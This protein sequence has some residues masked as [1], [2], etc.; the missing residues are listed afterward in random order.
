M[1]S[2]PKSFYNSA[3]WLAVRD[4]YLRQHPLC[5]DCLARGQYEIAAHVHHIIWLTPENYLNP[6]I[7]LNP[8]N[9]RAVCQPCHNM[10]HARR[11][12]R[13]YRVDEA[14]KIAPLAD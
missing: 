10:E 12:P 8:L 1:R 11:H 13:R 6:E 2:V 9:L 4:L 3:A 5:E 7:A 14:G